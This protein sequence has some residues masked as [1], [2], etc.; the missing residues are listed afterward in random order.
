MA[1]DTIPVLHC[2]TCW[3]TK[4]QLSRPRPADRLQMLLF[5]YPVRCRKCKSRVYASRAYAKYLRSIGQV[6]PKEGEE[7]KSDEMD[8]D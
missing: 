8:A 5:R 6:S 3:S 2:P 7:L 1:E 4:F